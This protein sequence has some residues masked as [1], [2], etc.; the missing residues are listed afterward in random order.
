M[1]NSR[2]IIQNW[3]HASPKSRWCNRLFREV[4]RSRRLKSWIFNWA[5]TKQQRKNIRQKKRTG[6]IELRR[7]QRIMHTSCTFFIQGYFDR[8]WRNNRFII[9]YSPVKKVEELPARYLEWWAPNVDDPSLPHHIEKCMHSIGCTRTCDTSSALSVSPSGHP[10]FPGHALPRR[11][12]FHNWGLIVAL[13]VGVRTKRGALGI[14]VK[15]MTNVKNRRRQIGRE[16]ERKREKDTRES[17]RWD[18]DYVPTG[19][20]RERIP[21]RYR[22]C[23]SLWG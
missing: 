19:T 8:S 13:P 11:G 1:S 14:K 7:I 12:R 21:L 17:E 9:N 22:K 4:V 15:G 20:Y 18:S 16:R 23:G 6:K 2:I 10:F 5:S 3:N